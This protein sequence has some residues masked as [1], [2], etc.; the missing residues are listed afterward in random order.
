M[1]ETLYSTALRRMDL[2]GLALYD[3]DLTRRLVM[4][5]EGKGRRDRVVPIGQ[6]AAA[7]LD[8]YLQEARPQLLIA[9]SEALFLTDY[10]EPITPEYVAERVSRYK[11]FPG[12]SKP[13]ACHLFRHA[14]TTQMLEN[15]ADKRFI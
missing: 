3:V 9:E 4:V 1:L 12:I 6:C 8:K 7:W 15:D 11:H 5:R 14:C 10:G 13:G 2:P